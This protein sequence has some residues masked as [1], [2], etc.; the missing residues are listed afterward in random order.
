MIFFPTRIRI[1]L[2]VESSFLF[3][4]RKESSLVILPV[5]FLHL[6]TFVIK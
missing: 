3:S 4:Y 5:D 6:K 1:D 2:S